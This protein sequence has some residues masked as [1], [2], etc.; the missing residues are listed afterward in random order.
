MKK[1]IAF[2]TAGLQFDGNSLTTTALGGSESALIYMA[3]ELQN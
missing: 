2:V 3:R 1:T